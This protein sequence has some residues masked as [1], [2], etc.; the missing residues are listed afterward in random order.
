MCASE[1]NALVV[2][3]Q[4]LAVANVEIETRH[5]ASLRSKRLSRQSH[6]LR[7]CPPEGEH[8]NQGQLCAPIYMKGRLHSAQLLLRLWQSLGEAACAVHLAG[9]HRGKAPDRHC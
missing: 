3:R 9:L 5:P 4:A 8:S 1:L 6:G 7:R 2:K